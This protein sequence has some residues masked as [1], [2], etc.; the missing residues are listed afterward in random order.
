MK[1]YNS[2]EKGYNTLKEFKNFLRKVPI[3]NLIIDEEGTSLYDYV[4]QVEDIL[5]SYEPLN[6]GQ[7]V[8]YFDYNQKRVLYDGYRRSWDKPGSG[9]ILIWSK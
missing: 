2:V 6:S 3:M 9:R 8:I 5:G 7:V 4:W 1:L